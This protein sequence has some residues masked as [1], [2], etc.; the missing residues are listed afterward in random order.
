MMI[1]VIIPVF[2]EQ[3]LI[4]STLNELDSFLL[5][6]YPDY[7]LIIVNDGSED[8]TGKVI[9]LWAESRAERTDRY[10]LLENETNRG[11]GYS[12]RRGMLEAGGDFRLFT[13]ADLPFEL[14]VIDKMVAEHRGGAQVVIGDR[15][16]PA[17]ILPPIRPIRRAA[18]RIY[19]FL[20]QLLI[21]GKISDTQCG[22]K[23]FNADAAEVVFPR[24]V[25][26]GFGF[27]VE[28][29]FIAQKHRL[30]IQRIP[31]R[32]IENRNESRVHLIKDSIK[33]FFNLFTIILNDFRGLYR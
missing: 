9:H 25:I 22:L 14:S 5:A 3:V 27:D 4:T 28:V 20:V 30:P 13:D 33:M 23:G 6:N 16:D 7:E 24:T 29:L 21:T 10:H 15:N 31:V 2:N 19:S 1:S 32:M 12:V 11:K 26:D 18:G 17:S 8:M